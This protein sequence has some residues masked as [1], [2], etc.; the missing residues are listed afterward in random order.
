MRGGGGLGGLLTGMVGGA[1][2]LSKGSL[3]GGPRGGAGGPDGLDGL[4]S[5]GCLDKSLPHYFH[6]LIAVLVVAT[7]VHVHLNADGHGISPI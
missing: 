4:G 5:L 3:G 2:S 7:F 6:S 1:L